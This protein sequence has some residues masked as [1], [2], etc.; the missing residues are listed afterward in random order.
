MMFLVLGSFTLMLRAPPSSF[1]TALKQPGICWRRDPQSTPVTSGPYGHRS[2]GVELGLR[3][4]SVCH[5]ARIII[6]LICYG[7]E[8]KTAND[9]WVAIAEEAINPL[10]D[11]L[12]P[13]A[14]LVDSL[15]FLKYVPSWLPGA[16]FKR[17]ARKWKDFATRLLNAP[18][19]AAKQNI[20]SGEYTPSFVSEL[21]QKLDD[22]V[23]A[24][25][26]EQEN[27][28][29]ETAG[30]MYIGLWSHG[31]LNWDAA[32]AD[33]TMAA[34]TSFLFAMLVAPDVQR[35]AQEEVDRVT[36]GRLPTFE[37]ERSMPYVTAVVWESLRWKNITPIGVPHYSVA[38]DEYNGYRIPKGSVVISNV[39]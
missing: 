20:E 9:P 4:A 28:I 19:V 24:G 22:D 1:S 31:H 32:G 35:K 7:L 38:E 16:G 8:V 14:F 3:D 10:M 6:M 33:T 5:S 30:N 26:Q 27:L 34:I 21:L 13:G 2:D 15:P 39:W 25:R 11:A 29:K 23:S 12:M 17:N 37:D 18:Y 36:P